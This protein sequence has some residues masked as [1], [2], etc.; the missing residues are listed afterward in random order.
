MNPELYSCTPFKEW[1]TF[2]AN[3]QNAVS[4]YKK[5]V[6][7][8][9]ISKEEADKLLKKEFEKTLPLSMKIQKL[10]DQT[11][12]STEKAVQDWK[13][14]P[15]GF[16]GPLKKKLVWLTQFGAIEPFLRLIKVRANSLKPKESAAEP[17]EFKTISD[18]EKKKLIKKAKVLKVMALVT[19]IAGSTLIA[20]GLLLPLIGS[21]ILIKLSLTTA[22]VTIVSLSLISGL[23]CFTFFAYPQLIN[24]SPSKRCRIH[25]D[26]T[27]QPFI[28][29]F[30]EFNK[31]KKFNISEK[32]LMDSKLHQIY[33]NWNASMKKIFT[34]K[35]MVKVDKEM[36]DFIAK[37]KE[38]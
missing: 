15:S 4:H 37:R 21:M 25:T 1:L 9:T 23:G 11:T 8:N 28:K 34:K 31:E 7:T 17:Y 38:I 22:L 16:F 27:F 13:E 18:E 35:K 19:L 32:D 29:L 14:T 2:N 6:T 5:N 33:L 3:F 20:G 24:A 30:V 36:E 26:P 12:K 10:I